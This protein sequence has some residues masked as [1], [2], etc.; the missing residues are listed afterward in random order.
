M[1]L[2]LLGETVQCGWCHGALVRAAG[3][4]AAERV[5]TQCCHAWLVAAA[6]IEMHGATDSGECTAPGVHTG[7]VW[8]V[9]KYLSQVV[10]DGHSIVP[11]RQG[12]PYSVRG[13]V[14]V[15]APRQ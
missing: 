5:Y 2:L 11:T 4:R 3:N 15:A 1:A 9:P 12:L 7:T 13:A 10:V 6:V 8:Q 14:E